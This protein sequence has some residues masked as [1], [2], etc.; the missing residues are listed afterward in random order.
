MVD[1]EIAV[2]HALYQEDLCFFVD[3]SVKS[4]ELAPD[5][6]QQLMVNA[7]NLTPARCFDLERAGTYESPLIL[8]LEERVLPIAAPFAQ[9]LEQK[10]V[11]LAGQTELK[12]PIEHYEQLLHFIILLDQ[13]VLDVDLLDLHLECY[14]S[15]CLVLCPLEVAHTLSQE[16]DLVAQ[17]RVLAIRVDLAAEAPEQL[18]AETCKFLLVAVLEEE[19][20]RVGLALQ[21]GR[22]L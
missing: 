18:R 21:R 15:Q 20:S 19:Q 11:L 2:W 13:R 6:C 16:A 5:S 1:V 14:L 3:G 8:A 17:G 7:D 4:S 22:T 10:G 12:L 9:V